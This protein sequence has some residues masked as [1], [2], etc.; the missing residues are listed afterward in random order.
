MCGHSGPTGSGFVVVKGTAKTIDQ[1]VNNTFIQHT[2]DPNQPLPGPLN[3]N[4]PQLELFAWAARSDLPLIE[5][6]VVEGGPAPGSNYFIDLSGFCDSGG[7]HTHVLSMIAYGLSLNSAQSGLANGLPGFVTDKFT[8]LTNTITAADSQID[9]SV[10][11]TVQGYVSQAQAVFN[12]G[13]ANWRRKLHATYRHGHL[14]RRIHPESHAL[15]HLG[16]RCAEY[17]DGVGRPGEL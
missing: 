4:C 8:N 6:S 16:L 13:A 5:G 14:H 17:R 9:L 10:A 15:G 7:G 3:L 11:A 2:V 1:N 12:S